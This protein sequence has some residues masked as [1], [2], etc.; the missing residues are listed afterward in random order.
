MSAATDVGKLLRPFW[1]R[2]TVIESPVDEEDRNGIIVPLT[3]DEG[4]DFLRGVVQHVDQT[5]HDMD[6][7]AEYVRKIAP[8]TVVF[9]R[10]GVRIRDSY[11]VEIADILA[12]EADE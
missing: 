1:G 9:F 2:V 7:W 12:F 10:K 8:G 6:S 3:R 11:V 4:G 5:Y